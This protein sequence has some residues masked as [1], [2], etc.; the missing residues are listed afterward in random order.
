MAASVEFVATSLMALPHYA[1]YSRARTERLDDDHPVAQYFKQ[2]VESKVTRHRRRPTEEHKEAPKL[3]VTRVEQIRV[4]RLQEKYLAEVQ[5]I[6]GLCE[7]KV[8][9]NLTDLLDAPRVESFNGLDLNEVS[10][11]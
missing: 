5:D 10:A 3:S 9:N 11:E 4:R 2:K 6:A 7:N 8:S 1:A